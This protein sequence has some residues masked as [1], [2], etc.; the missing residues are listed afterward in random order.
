MIEDIP[1]RLLGTCIAAKLV[2][3]AWC[4]WRDE[5]RMMNHDA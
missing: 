4:C 5:R 1:W 2:F 3:V